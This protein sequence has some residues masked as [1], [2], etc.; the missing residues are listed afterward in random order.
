MDKA[1]RILLWILLALFLFA[2]G[3]VGMGILRDRRA[4]AIQDRGPGLS[5]PQQ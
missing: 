1:T 2:A 3:F 5:L 4:K